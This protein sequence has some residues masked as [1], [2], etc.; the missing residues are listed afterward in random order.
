MAPANDVIAERGEGS[1]A[2]PKL[3]PENRV[4][5]LL[6]S[7]AAVALLVAL[8]FG[9]AGRLDWLA[10]WVYLALLV[11]TV[12]VNYR[13]LKR[14]NPE[15]I[16][17]RLHLGDGTKLWDKWWSG[18]FSPLYLSLY[19]VAGLDAV[20]FG[21]SSPPP[22]LWPIGLAVFL[23]G[24]ALLIASMVVNPFFEK[25]VR[26]QTE[27]GHRVIDTGPY[28]FVRHPGYVGFLAWVVSAP[29]GLRRVREARAFPA[30]PQDLVARAQWRGRGAMRRI[31]GSG[32]GSNRAQ[33]A[34]GPGRPAT[35]R[36]DPKRGNF[37]WPDAGLAHRKRLDST[38]RDP[39]GRLQRGFESPPLRQL[40]AT[41]SLR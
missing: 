9:P 5:L 24:S 14:W 4:R 22:W 36:F 3:S 21:W 16:D 34:G 37:W 8:I 10:G 32:R 39:S 13:C 29:Q 19:V 35:P 41:S 40:L 15:L 30:R 38:R 6:W 33:I 27:H 28:A 12:V 18:I 25:T 7:T 1:R 26:I 11:A 2:E 23:A 17:R 31:W 20:R